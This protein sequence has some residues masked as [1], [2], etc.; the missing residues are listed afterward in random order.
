V[1]E[2]IV[3][4]VAAG[5]AALWMSVRRP[6]LR[7]LTPSLRFAEGPPPL[8]RW[9]TWRT[10]VSVA[11]LVVV[12]LVWGDALAW[13]STGPAAYLTGLAQAAAFA[14]AAL[15]LAGA[16]VVALAGA[17]RRRPQLRHL[18]LP[19]SRLLGVWGLL[20]ALTLALPPLVDTTGRAPRGLPPLAAMLV[21]LV[22]TLL[23]LAV[24]LA[25]MAFV[26][27][28]L[29]AVTRHYFCAVDAH[30]ALRALA[31]LLTSVL[32]LGWTVVGAVNGGPR[33]DLPPGLAVAVSLAGPVAVAA[34]AAE[35]LRRLHARGR[36]VRYVPGP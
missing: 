11:S 1:P 25:A 14:S 23:L 26:W 7:F 21:Q 28:A 22:V 36:L 10:V 4:G 30:P 12:H 18:R 16:A 9:A 27:T 20:G 2:S 35:E 34:V 29:P 24:L 32:V 6:T 31:E 33:S 3:K 8:E 5:V 19:L 15:V 17:G 13:V